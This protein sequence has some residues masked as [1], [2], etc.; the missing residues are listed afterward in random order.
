MVNNSTKINKTNNH[1]SSWIAEN[2]TTFDGENLDIATKMWRVKSIY[3]SP[4]LLSWKPE[5][6][7]RVC[8]C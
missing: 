8:Y 5:R 6:G 2:I 4:A 7:E 3:G 1:L